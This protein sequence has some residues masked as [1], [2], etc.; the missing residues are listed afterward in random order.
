MNID[1]VIVWEWQF[2]FVSMFFHRLYSEPRSNGKYD[3]L[4]LIET[5][6]SHNPGHLFGH[7]QFSN[8]FLSNKRVQKYGWFVEI[9]LRSV[10]SN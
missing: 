7:D 8:G 5:D 3:Q 9:I 6:Y 4:N 2:A 10:V 1:S